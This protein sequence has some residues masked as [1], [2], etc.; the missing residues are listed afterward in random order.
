M[1]TS[2]ILF[3]LGGAFTGIENIIEKRTRNKKLGFSAPDASDNSKVEMLEVTGNDLVSY[4]LIREFVGRIP[5]ISPIHPLTEKDLR[6]II[7]R[8]KHSLLKTINR[9]SRKYGIH[10]NFTGGAL[11]AIA[12]DAIQKG[13]CARSLSGTINKIIEPYIFEDAQVT[14]KKEITIEITIQDIIEGLN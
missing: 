2:G 10:F 3:V 1:D 8:G 11:E 14:Y 12:N 9:D 4:G 6:K 13:T 7:A 5:V